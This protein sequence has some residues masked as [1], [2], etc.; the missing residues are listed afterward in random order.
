MSSRPAYAQAEND[1]EA[2]WGEAADLVSWFT[3]P[4][5]VREGDTWFPG[6][7]L[8]ACFNAVDRHVVAGRADRVALVGD[9]TS[10]V[11]ADLLELSAVLG[12][13]LTSLGAAPGAHVAVDLPVSR[14]SVVIA[15]ACARIGATRAP[16]ALAD[17]PAVTVTRDGDGVVLRPPVAD[18]LGWDL[19]VRA[20]RT[21][22]AA[23]VDLP[24]GHPLAVT[25]DG[26]VL[27]TGRHTAA[28]A[29][30]RATGYVPVTD[31]DDALAAL[32]SGATVVL[33]AGGE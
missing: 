2:F 30:E 19:A 28:L 26:T 20:G 10:V 32:V 29:W 8:N 22:P 11:Y 7:S 31:D 9:G 23:S 16:L 5:A 6:W 27:D 25:A 3:R 33:D 4:S 13:V 17:A 14:E 15:L 21:D 1:P 18:P 24:A 12:G